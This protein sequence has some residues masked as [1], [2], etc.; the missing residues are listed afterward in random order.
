M[1]VLMAQYFDAFARAFSQ[2]GGVVVGAL[3]IALHSFFTMHIRALLVP[4]CSLV[5]P[6]PRFD[7]R[8]PRAGGE[9]P[10]IT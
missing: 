1:Q 2:A 3:A 8:G 10:D 9:G 6:P 7:T 5:T 4:R